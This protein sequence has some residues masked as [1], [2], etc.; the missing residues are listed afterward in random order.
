[1]E[2]HMAESN[3]TETLETTEEPEAVVEIAEN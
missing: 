3:Q 1:M 2:R